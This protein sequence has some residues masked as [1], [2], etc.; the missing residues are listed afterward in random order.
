MNHGSD[1]E[2]CRLVESS[3]ASTMAQRLD[4][5]DVGWERLRRA[6]TTMED[7]RVCQPYL[8]QLRRCVRT[9]RR[10]RRRLAARCE[11]PKRKDGWDIPN[12]TRNRITVAG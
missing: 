8:V 6:T 3:D 12:E 10:R 9:Q 7:G 5:M 4:A 11:P 1:S 2:R